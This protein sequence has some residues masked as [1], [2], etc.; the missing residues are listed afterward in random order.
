MNHQA[1]KIT[2]IVLSVL[3]FTSSC[4]TTEEIKGQQNSSTVSIASQSSSSQ[5]AASPDFYQTTLL[6]KLKVDAIVENSNKESNRIVLVQEKIFD[7]TKVVHAFF[8]NQNVSS[9][10]EDELKRYTLDG[11]ILDIG[12]AG[13]L[14]FNTV[15]AQYIRTVLENEPKK[16]ELADQDL[17]GFPKKQAIKQATDLMKELKITPHLPPHVYSLDCNFLQNKQNELMQDDDFMYFVK[18]GKTKLKDNW[19]SQDDSYYLVFN[20]ESNGIPISSTSYH[21]NTSEVAVEGSQVSIIVSKSGVQ[22][23]E[24]NGVL[25]NE[26]GNKPAGSLITMEKAL[27]GLKQKYEKIILNED[28]TVNRISL[29]YA[30]VITGGSVDKQTGE[31]NNKKIELTP[32]W[33]FTI[34]SKYVKGGKE[35][36]REFIVQINAVTGKEIL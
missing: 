16:E 31:I 13:H 9:K 17:N 36:T 4:S 10:Q 32:A 30:P 11:A 21:L 29:V 25:Y 19:T 14:S 2:T 28:L 35:F 5:V 7:D 22:S 33:S 6:E 8:N 27:E 34:N 12:S 1:P 3:L 26:L 20:I 18:I 15:S 23:F 24:V